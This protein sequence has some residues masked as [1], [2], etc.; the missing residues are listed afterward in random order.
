MEMS[1]H[2][3]RKYSSTSLDELEKNLA[4]LDDRRGRLRVDS[5]LDLCVR[6]NYFSDLIS[7]LDDSSPRRR[8]SIAWI[9][10]RAA[11]QKKWLPL[12]HEAE[13]LIDRLSEEQD[14]MTK[15]GII[16]VFQYGP[17][18]KS[19]ESQMLDQCISSL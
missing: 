2:N 14:V 4:A 10:A 16:D 6:K 5:T 8:G 18:P 17:I 3:G 12:D 9:L 19:K 1:G 15:R 11:Q 13:V 7:M